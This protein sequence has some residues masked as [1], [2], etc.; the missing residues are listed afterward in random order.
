MAEIKKIT[1]RF[2]LE[3]KRDKGLWNL[4]QNDNNTNEY[5]KNLI[6]EAI[7]QQQQQSVLEEVKEAVNE[8][9][10]MV[11]RLSREGMSMPNILKDAADG[12]KKNDEI[13][14]ADSN[15]EYIAKN[16]EVQPNEGTASAIDAEVMDF[17][18]NL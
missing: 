5:I 11:K 16:L 4:I 8:I 13:I 18:N 9:K 6:Q 15:N 12:M 10:D 17:L 3:N 7:K 2:Y 14:T 1:L